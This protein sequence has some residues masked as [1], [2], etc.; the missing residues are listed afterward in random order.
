MV[1]FSPGL[2]SVKAGSDEEAVENGHFDALLT[3]GM[4]SKFLSS[5]SDLTEHDISVDEEWRHL[6]DKL[7]RNEIS[8]DISL[9]CWLQ[10]FE[11][12]MD[13]LDMLL[14]AISEHTDKRNHKKLVDVTGERIYFV[15]I[16]LC[17]SA[18]RCKARKFCV[19]NA[20]QALLQF[21]EYCTSLASDIGYP[22]RASEYL[23]KLSFFSVYSL[24]NLIKDMEL[25]DIM[26]E[27]DI[28][29]RLRNILVRNN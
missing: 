28:S 25:H 21:T 12:S 17:E 27:A 15:G 3:Q 1:L 2:T 14:A 16:V 22:N 18:K 4:V 9:D 13:A 5:W 20:I 26:F 29:T 19:L 10:M 23:L 8:P 7:K 6:S 11:C 24:Q